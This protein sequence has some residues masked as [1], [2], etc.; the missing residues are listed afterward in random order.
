M[1]NIPDIVGWTSLHV[2][3]YYKRPDVMLL[4]LKNGANLL[5]KDREGI[6]PI[7][8]V[9]ENEECL[10]VIN[11]F[12]SFNINNDSDYDNT[13]ESD[14]TISYTKKNHLKKLYPKVLNK[15]ANHSQINI[16][17]YDEEFEE[18]TKQ[19]L[20]NYKYIPKRHKFYYSY[21]NNTFDYY[22]YYDG[23]LDKVKERSDT[24]PDNDYIKYNTLK[25]IKNECIETIPYDKP[26]KKQSGDLI[27]VP[28]IFPNVKPFEKIKNPLNFL[29][30]SF[31]NEE[32]KSN[33]IYKS[34]AL[35]SAR[36]INI[37]EDSLNYS[38]ESLNIDDLNLDDKRNLF[39]LSRRRLSR[40]KHGNKSCDVLIDMTKSI[41]NEDT[42]SNNFEDSIYFS[43]KLP[44]YVNNNDNIVL[45]SIN[46]KI[47]DIPETEYF[48]N[49]IKIGEIFS[50]FYEFDNRTIEDYLCFIFE[51]DPNFGLLIMLNIF[52]CENNNGR[53]INLLRKELKNRTL[54]G[55]IISQNY[56]FENGRILNI[57]KIYLNSFDFQKLP[58]KDCI[59][60][61]LKCNFY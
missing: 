37:M 56:T 57:A 45:N 3:S 19:I 42:I 8:L 16:N 47:I 32:Y 55:S 27:K 52:N 25:K 58:L 10:K 34:T 24:N 43:E 5:T 12:M 23:N 33:V 29:N 26:R 4:L 31:E 49:Y 2:A 14:R 54:L 11:A 15:D 35:R 59:K 30:N 46:T 60:K 6:A 41:D 50:K 36:Y 13:Y 40:N 39:P 17:Q 38:Q 51:H 18:Q 53:L 20:E 7:D 22:I 9:F 61:C 28:K 44:F 1:I 21:I 48:M